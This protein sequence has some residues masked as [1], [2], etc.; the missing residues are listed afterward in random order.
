[1]RFL[2]LLLQPWELSTLPAWLA[3]NSP[4]VP[5]PAGF[6]DCP[7]WGA[8]EERPITPLL[9]RRSKEKLLCG[10]HC[11]LGL[12]CLKAS[13]FA[14]NHWHETKVRLLN[15]IKTVAVLAQKKCCPFCARFV[16]LLLGAPGCGSVEIRVHPQSVVQCHEILALVSLKAWKQ[17]SNLSRAIRFGWFPGCCT[18]AADTAMPH[19]KSLLVQSYLGIFTWCCRGLVPGVFCTNKSILFCKLSSL[20]ILG[21]ENSRMWC[22]KETSIQIPA[23]LFLLVLT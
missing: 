7:K 3:F 20:D 10:P 5:M 14:M 16:L 1:M 11:Q 19:L 13:G 21:Q 9:I 23:V 18:D 15:V 8:G 22:E 12:S 17:R 4:A 2:T 6:P